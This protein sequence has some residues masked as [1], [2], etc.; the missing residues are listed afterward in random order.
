M[1]YCIKSQRL[2]TNLCPYIF[3]AGLLK[4]IRL[5]EPF[6]FFSELLYVLFHLL[7]LIELLA[8]IVHKLSQETFRP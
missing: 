1:I 8:Q 7:I 2:K 3:P 5:L 4:S 6:S